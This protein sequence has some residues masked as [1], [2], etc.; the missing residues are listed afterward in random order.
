[1]SLFWK[2]IAEAAKRCETEAFQD[3]EAFQERSR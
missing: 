3:L 2:C 1:M